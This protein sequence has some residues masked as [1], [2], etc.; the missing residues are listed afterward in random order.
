VLSRYDVELEL[1]DARDRG[2]LFEEVFERLLTV[3]RGLAVA[4]KGA[5]R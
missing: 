3:R 1:A 2:R 4:R 5:G